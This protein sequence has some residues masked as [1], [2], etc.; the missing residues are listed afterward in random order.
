MHKRSGGQGL[1]LR[2][3]T[4]PRGSVVA[5]QIVTS[6]KSQGPPLS[7][8]DPFIT[9]Y[10]TTNQFH[11]DRL[12]PPPFLPFAAGCR[13]E[14]YGKER[15]DARAF[16]ETPAAGNGREAGRV[17]EPGKSAKRRGTSLARFRC[18]F[19]RFDGK[20]AESDPPGQRPSLCRFIAVLS[21]LAPVNMDLSSYFPHFMNAAALNFLRY[22]LAGKAG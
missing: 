17:K 21:G 6:I 18:R 19:E 1:F 20:P 5:A 12:R 7:S 3:D 4:V 13:T 22:S 10:R 9:N 8:A 11:I 15:D 16:Q 14:A 2:V